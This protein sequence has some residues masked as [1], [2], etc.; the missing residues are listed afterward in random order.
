MRTAR[1]GRLIE[2]RRGPAH[3]GAGPDRWPPT[4]FT[5]IRLR[6]RFLAPIRRPRISEAR[7][8]STAHGLRETQHD[9]PAV[10]TR[11]RQTPDE[12]PVDGVECTEHLRGRGALSSWDGEHAGKVE[13]A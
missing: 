5:A 12:G 13:V 4:P 11:R 9:H 2:A 10:L 7:G 3:A 6:S 8:R 1:T